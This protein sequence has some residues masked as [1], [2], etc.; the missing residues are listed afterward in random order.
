MVVEPQHKCMLRVKFFT[1]A[2]ELVAQ[3]GMP[4]Q[5][6]QEMRELV[7]GEMED[8][9]RRGLAGIPPALVTPMQLR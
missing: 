9:L 6:L 7:L 2:L 4:L 1:K 5:L 8:V 3:E